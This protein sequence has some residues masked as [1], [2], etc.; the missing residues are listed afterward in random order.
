MQNLDWIEKYYEV[1]K[2]CN[3][4]SIRPDIISVGNGWYEFR[5]YT[6]GSSFSTRAS[7]KQIETMTKVLQHRI[8]ERKN[9]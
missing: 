7:K 1:F 8:E 5:S 6:G 3:P 4:T 9:A 2:E